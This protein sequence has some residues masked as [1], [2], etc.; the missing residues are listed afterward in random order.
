MEEDPSPV[1]IVPKVE[2]TVETENEI[3]SNISEKNGNY[4]RCH[5]SAI[6]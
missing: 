4:L 1:E 5:E 3:K 2:L 6:P